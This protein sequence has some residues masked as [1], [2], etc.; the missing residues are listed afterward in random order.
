MLGKAANCEYGSAHFESVRE[1]RVRETSTRWPSARSSP[2]LQ[3]CASREQFDGDAHTMVEAGCRDTRSQ[4]R[5][6]HDSSKNAARLRT[7]MK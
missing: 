3:M 5:R 2:K 1:R 4:L 6:S 7:P